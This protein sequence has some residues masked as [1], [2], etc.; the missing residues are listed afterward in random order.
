[1]TISSFDAW[2]VRF[3]L[4]S[5]EKI[6]NILAPEPKIKKVEEKKVLLVH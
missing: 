2:V 1:M 4:S 3:E 6:A 5:E